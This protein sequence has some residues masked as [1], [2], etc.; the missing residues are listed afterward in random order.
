MISISFLVFVVFF[1]SFFI[2]CFARSIRLHRLCLSNLRTS[3][4]L[5]ISDPLG[6]TSD[7]QV[8]VDA[9]NYQPDVPRKPV[10][11]VCQLFSVS[12]SFSFAFFVFSSSLF[13]F[14]F[15][16]I[17]NKV[18]RCTSSR[19][20]GLTGPEKQSAI[21]GRR[22]SDTRLGFAQGHAE[23]EVNKR[24]AKNEGETRGNILL[25]YM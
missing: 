7:T 20:Y 19:S 9:K 5:F 14:C 1:C 24:S 25:R 23:N 4:T 3:P 10:S 15:S 12:H 21:E 11:I 16:G 13:V 8:G 17:V 6:R 22:S 2:A 18:S